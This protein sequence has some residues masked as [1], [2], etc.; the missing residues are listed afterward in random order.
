[1]HPSLKPSSRHPSALENMYIPPE[2]APS[3]QQVWLWPS[4]LGLTCQL[5]HSLGALPF[6]PLYMNTSIAWVSWLAF[7]SARCYL[8]HGNKW[9]QVTP[10]LVFP[11]KCLRGDLF[12]VASAYGGCC[13]VTT[14]K[15]NAIWLVGP[16]AQYKSVNPKVISPR[17]SQSLKNP[18]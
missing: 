13:G 7:L 2:A 8:C 14:G 15:D 12:L 5:S 3:L 18:T 16:W 1:M 9:M 11:Y 17:H 4:G 10:P 6:H